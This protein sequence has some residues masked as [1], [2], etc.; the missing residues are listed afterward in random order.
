MVTRGNAVAIVGEVD[1]GTGPGR[2]GSLGWPTGGR[3][4]RLAQR[5]LRAC[6]VLALRPS[7]RAPK[8]VFE[9]RQHAERL[10]PKRQQRELDGAGQRR[11]LPRERRR[12]ETMKLAV[13]Y[14]PG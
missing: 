12:G 3:Q 1:A 8:G 2:A 11:A 9:H 10:Q 7:S 4:P 5:L 14:G 13:L 6:H